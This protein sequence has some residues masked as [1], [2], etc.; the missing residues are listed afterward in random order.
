[1]QQ[2]ACWI[3]HDL[4]VQSPGQD[5]PSF[6]VNIQQKISKDLPSKE[7]CLFMMGSIDAGRF[8]KISLGGCD[9]C[10]GADSMV[11]AK[12]TG[13][14]D[15]LSSAIAN[16]IKKTKKNFTRMKSPDIHGSVLECWCL[17]ESLVF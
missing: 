17:L 7:E 14:P 15:N 12:G 3:A 11:V 4:Y 10:R 13:T 2:R 16:N 1:M 5:V 9:Q 8:K 6:C